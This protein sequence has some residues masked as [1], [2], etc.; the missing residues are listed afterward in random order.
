MTEISPNKLSALEQRILNWS[1]DENTTF[2]P[3]S[4]EIASF[5]KVSRRQA[6]MAVQGLLR[7]QVLQK[8]SPNR[9]AWVRE[10]QN[11]SQESKL[12]TKRNKNDTL[13]QKLQHRIEEGHYPNGTEL[14]SLKSLALELGCSVYMVQQILKIAEEKKW[15]FQVGKKRWVGSHHSFTTSSN[16]P[17]NRILLLIQPTKNRW[18][19]MSQNPR[20]QSFVIDFSQYC[21]KHNIRFVTSDFRPAKRATWSEI[22]A[23][24]S[25]LHQNFSKRIAGALIVG[26]PLAWGQ[27]FKPIIRWCSRHNLPTVWLDD[28]DKGNDDRELASQYVRAHTSESAMMHMAVN[29]MQEKRIKRACYLTFN[30][31]TWEKERYLDICKKAQDE[32]IDVEHVP[33]WQPFHFGET[34]TEWESLLIQMLRQPQH[35]HGDCSKLL[36]QLIAIDSKL[37]KRY[38]WIPLESK[39]LFK[40]PGAMK[41]IRAGM[42]RSLDLDQE[43][44]YKVMFVGYCIRLDRILKA[45]P[46]LIICS[47]Q[48]NAFKIYKALNYIGLGV[49]KDFK[50]LTFDAHPAGLFG[51][52]DTVDFGLGGLAHKTFRFFWDES[53]NRAQRKRLQAQPHYISN[54]SI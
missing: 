15:I 5:C 30:E 13:L 12:E 40:F 7:A 31:Q 1:R 44:V 54:G 45:R 43:D 47:N 49:P 28:A 48:E 6:M 50:M 41:A 24:L 21:F 4:R 51:F 42:M 18:L 39:G 8:H 26:D 29:V 32:D 20:V 23:N 25:E 36:K 52:I 37:E 34:S 10:R 17:Q 16:Q 46:E 2:V 22:H 9:Y 19:S 3:S 35:F 27:N 14:P 33:Y 53:S 38:D 11:E